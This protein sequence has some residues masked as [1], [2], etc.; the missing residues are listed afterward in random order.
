M[1][2]NSLNHFY[3][4]HKIFL[5]GYVVVSD[6]SYGNKCLTRSSRSANVSLY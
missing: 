2:R 4:F 6:S 1:K 5:R 3:D